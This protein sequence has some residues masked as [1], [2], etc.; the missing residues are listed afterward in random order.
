MQTDP[1]A[2]AVPRAPA[3]T[4]EVVRVLI[5]AEALARDALLQRLDVLAALDHPHVARV[6]GLTPH[7]AGALEVRI[8]RP[9]AAD[10]PTALVARAPLTPAEASCVVVTVA[11]ALAALHSAGLTQGSVDAGDVLLRPDGTP[12]LRPRLDLPGPV[13]ADPEAFAT[14]ASDDV[15]SLAAMVAALL[16]RGTAPALEAELARALAADLRDRPEAGTLAARVHAALPPEPVRVPEPAALVSAALTG[17]HPVVAPRPP[18]RRRATLPFAHP[19]GVAGGREARGGRVRAAL[20]RP[21]VLIGAAGSAGRAGPARSAGP[22]RGRGGRPPQVGHMLVAVLVGVLSGL[23]VGAIGSMTLAGAAG[24]AEAGLA[25]D[26]V[27]RQ[28]GTSTDPVL[29]PADPE[30]AAAT[31]TARRLALLAGATSDLTA[32]DAPGSAAL[33]ADAALVANL[34]MSGTTIVGATAEVTSAQVVGHSERDGAASRGRDG[35]QT[36]GEVDVVVGYEVAAHTQVGADGRE[37]Q[38]PASGPRTATLTLAWTD[39]GWRV[40]AVG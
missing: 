36:P 33:A 19:R 21:A 9:D 37:T 27:T 23:G 15:R 13:P 38:V 29:D 30:T 3:V 31:L 28:G 10:L 35:A 7:G 4:A 1:A 17:Q 22:R 11:Q 5:P 2:P 40:V 8:A 6:L 14:G 18:G 26:A 25:P 16:P 20:A 39:A 32:V 12:F 34:T 24:P